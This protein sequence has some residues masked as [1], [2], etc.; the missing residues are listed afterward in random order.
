MTRP[1]RLS[2]TEQ[3]DP[4]PVVVYVTR[5]ARSFFFSGSPI[6]PGTA[7]YGNDG[8]GRTPRQARPAHARAPAALGQGREGERVARPRCIPWP[9]T[10]SHRTTRR[11]PPSRARRTTGRISACPAG[12]PRG[13]VPELV[14]PAR[15]P[16]AAGAAVA[17]SAEAP[18]VAVVA[19]WDSAGELAVA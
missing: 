17:A 10:A 12:A 11:R 3:Y 6:L 16:L 4:R 8:V 5:G 15:V 13:P 14:G 9:I 7:Q 18:G 19:D 2:R 1:R